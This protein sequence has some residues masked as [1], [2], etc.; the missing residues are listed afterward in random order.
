MHRPF[1]KDMKHFL[2]MPITCTYLETDGIVHIQSLEIG[3][4][5]K[6]L[7]LTNTISLIN[8]KKSQTNFTIIY[9]YF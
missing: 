7:Y 3:F 5:K 8:D 4:V 1:P 9:L 6:C 2:V